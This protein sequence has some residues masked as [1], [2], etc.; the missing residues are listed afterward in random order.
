MPYGRADTLEISMF[1]V[2][3]CSYS[4]NVLGAFILH[5]STDTVE[6]SNSNKS[7]FLFWDSISF[8]NLH[9]LRV[10]MFQV[11]SLC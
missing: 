9:V 1:Y 7:V 8:R 4:L 2:S 11:S 6:V 5:G 3:S 10:F